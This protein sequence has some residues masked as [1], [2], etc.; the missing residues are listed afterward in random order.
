MK[1]LGMS[2]ESSNIA[3]F[4]LADNQVVSKEKASPPDFMVF[5]THDDGPSLALF[6]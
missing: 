5:Q 2:F 3:D 4:D 1:T 6:P